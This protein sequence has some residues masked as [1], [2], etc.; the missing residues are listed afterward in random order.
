MPKR[1]STA[2]TRKP[3]STICDGAL[4]HLADLRDPMKSSKDC[5]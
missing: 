1:F 5:I 4:H 3:W 2:P